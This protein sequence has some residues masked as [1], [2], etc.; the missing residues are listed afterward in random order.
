MQQCMRCLGRSAL[1]FFWWSAVSICLYI[2]HSPAVRLEGVCEWELHFIMHYLFH[3]LFSP[4]RCSVVLRAPKSKTKPEAGMYRAVMSCACR[5]L[6]WIG[7]SL[8]DLHFVYNYIR[9]TIFK[10]VRV[11]WCFYFVLYR[12]Q[13]QSEA[14]HCLQLRMALSKRELGNRYGPSIK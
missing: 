9:W 5:L 14:Y 10:Q 1:F 3:V 12:M 7:S 8:C 11:R 4:A 2:W 13:I 6:L